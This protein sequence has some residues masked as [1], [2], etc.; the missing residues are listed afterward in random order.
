APPWPRA[1]P[2]STGRYHWLPRRPEYRP[3]VREKCPH[4]SARFA[5]SEAA[6]DRWS[7]DPKTPVAVPAQLAATFRAAAVFHWLLC[8]P[9]SPSSLLVKTTLLRTSL[10][11]TRTPASTG[12]ETI[13]RPCRT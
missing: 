3:L 5:R 6:A 8:R 11:R 2:T 7:V 12:W 13:Q 4:R 9:C 10:A 1:L